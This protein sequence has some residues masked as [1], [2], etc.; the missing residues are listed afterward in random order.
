MATFDIEESRI[1]R[2]VEPDEI[3]SFYIDASEGFAVKSL[4]HPAAFVP[5]EDGD[6]EVTS[7]VI[8]IKV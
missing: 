4:A 8:D 7:E 6:K 3:R 1:R 2:K 5:Q